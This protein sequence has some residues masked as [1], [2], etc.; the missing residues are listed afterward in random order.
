[1]RVA[2]WQWTFP[3]TGRRQARARAEERTDCRPDDGEACPR[4][5]S[6]ATAHNMGCDGRGRA[7]RITSVASVVSMHLDLPFGSVIALANGCSSI[8]DFVLK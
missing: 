1:M 2:L 7:G 4:V 5:G 3:R 6:E 8:V